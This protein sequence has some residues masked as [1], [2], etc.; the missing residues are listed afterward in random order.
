VDHHVTRLSRLD[1]P[2]LISE[3][4][5]NCCSM[6]RVVT[7]ML[8]RVALGEDKHALCEARKQAAI[9]WCSPTGTAAR[10]CGDS[11]EPSPGML[12]ACGERTTYPAAL[13][14]TSGS[15]G[16]AFPMFSASN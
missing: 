2:V 12:G 4:W 13:V 7:S 6:R 9:G 15:G 11:V 5:Y 3:S 10:V 8:Q 14:V 16:R 1:P